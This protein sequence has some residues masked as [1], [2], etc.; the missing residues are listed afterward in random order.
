MHPISKPL[1]RPRC[2]TRDCRQSAAVYVTRARYGRIASRFGVGLWTCSHYSASVP[3]HMYHQACRIAYY[4]LWYSSWPC[5]CSHYPTAGWF[6]L[7]GVQPQSHQN[8]RLSNAAPAFQSASHT[9]GIAYIPTHQAMPYG[10]ARGLDILARL[11]RYPNCFFMQGHVTL[12]TR[13]FES[14]E[15]HALECKTEQN[16]CSQQRGVPFC[17]TAYST[18]TTPQHVLENY[19][20][21]ILR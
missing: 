17:S 5:W 14:M 18:A 8:M 3:M 2:I 9:T 6:L 16:T 1:P 20:Q 15:V 13:L 11:V 21:S 19:T 10:Y 7:T 12:S 4:H